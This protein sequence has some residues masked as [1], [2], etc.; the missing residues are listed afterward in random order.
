MATSM[1]VIHFTKQALNALVRSRMRTAC[2]ARYMSQNAGESGPSEELQASYEDE[3]EETEYE[4]KLRILKSSLPFVHQHGWTSNALAQGA[5]MEGLPGIAHGLFPKGGVELVF[6]FYTDCNK[7]LANQ[8]AEK[9]QQ[10]K[11]AEATQAGSGSGPKIRPFIRDAVETRLRMIIPYMDKWPQA[12]GIMALPQNAPGA[13]V[14]LKDLT[15]EIWYHAGDQS[16]DFN[17]YTK[18]AILAALYK[19]TEVYMVQD[20]SEDYQQTWEFL[21]RRMA[22]LTNF[23]KITRSGQEMGTVMQEACKGLAIVGRNIL[24]ANSRLK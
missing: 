13:L 15:D 12:M 20:K 21:D 1:N 10:E 17:W 2:F 5:E 24:G 23:G 16:T 3:G 4:T 22:N 14:H 8:L 18:R 6:Y 19:S 11:E 9:V 7:Q